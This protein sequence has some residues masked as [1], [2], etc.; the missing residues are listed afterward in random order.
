MAGT[1]HSIPN[2]SFFLHIDLGAQ[3]ASKFSA[4]GKIEFHIFPP[5]PWSE[6]LPRASKDARDLVSRLIRYESRDRLSADA[7]SFCVPLSLF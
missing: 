5:K 7:V 1:K 6:I 3:E 4:W 2:L